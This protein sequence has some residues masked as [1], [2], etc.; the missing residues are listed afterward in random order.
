MQRGLLSFSCT[1]IEY[2]KRFSLFLLPCKRYAKRS[3]LFL[4]HM[5]RICKEVF[6]LSLTHAKD[7]QRGLLSLSY[8]WIGYA[9][10]SS[11]FL[12]HMLRICK[13]VFSLSQKQ[14]LFSYFTY[15]YIGFPY[16]LYNLLFYL[17]HD[18]NSDIAYL[19]IV[20]QKFQVYI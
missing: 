4:L 13:K 7:M 15:L 20:R 18:D 10:R 12:L 2:A 17:L 9:K 5:D 1:W 11:L 14:A 19:Y 6:S 16:C 3:S 8:T